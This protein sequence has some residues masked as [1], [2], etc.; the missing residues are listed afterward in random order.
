VSDAALATT[1]AVASRFLAV[2]TPRTI[3]LVGAGELP[4]LMLDAHRAYFA[5]RE[6]RCTDPAVAA[7]LGGR[8]TTIAEA[9]AADIVC[10]CADGVRI[11]RA[12]IRNGTH[13]NVAAYAMVDEE[14]LSV[15]KVVVSEGTRPG[16]WGT[17][18]EIVSGVKDG[19]E[20][21]ELTVF[22]AR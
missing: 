10:V 16:M 8:A 3:G 7:A 12:W 4:R 14:I 5:P 15:A 19:R 21:D 13:L 17:L 20:V 22:L 1:C 11:E 2:G 18:G 6:I 9:C